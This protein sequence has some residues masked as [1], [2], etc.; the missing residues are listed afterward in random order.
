[1]GTVTET[2]A[3]VNGRPPVEINWDLFEQHLKAAA[4]EEEICR[5]FNI[6]VSTLQ[7]HI[8]LRYGETVTFPQVFE[9]FSGERNISLR[10]MRFNHAKKNWHAC[11]ELCARY[12]GEYPLVGTVEPTESDF[13]PKLDKLFDGYS[14]LQEDYSALKQAEISSNEESK[15]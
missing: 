8:K 15:S 5:F 10:R 2:S 14:K 11:Q 12:L 13:A 4:T 6:A 1:M 9:R 7:R 3:P